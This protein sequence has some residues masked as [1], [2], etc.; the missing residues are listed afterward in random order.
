M[1]DNH[2]INW[3]D[4][5][6]WKDGRVSYGAKTMI[7]ISLLFAVAFTGISLPGVLAVPEEIDKGN[8]AVLLVLD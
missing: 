8:Y 5:G 1:E 7:W 2:Y 3:Q 4:I 6:D